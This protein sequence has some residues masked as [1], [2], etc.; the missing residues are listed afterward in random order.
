MCSRYITRVLF[1]PRACQPRA[2]GGRRGLGGGDVTKLTPGTARAAR[3]ARA[4]AAAPTVA[5]H[6]R[7]AR[8]QV[9]MAGPCHPAARPSRSRQPPPRQRGARA[10]SSAPSTAATPRPPSPAAPP[11]ATV[12]PT[13]RARATWPA[14]RSARAPRREGRQL[15]HKT[16]LARAED[17]LARVWYANQTST[18]R[19]RRAGITFVGARTHTHIR[20]TS[21]IQVMRVGSCARARVPGTSRSSQHIACSKRRAPRARPIETGAC[22][23]LRRAA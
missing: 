12:P 14:A 8:R 2:A 7:L 21:S 19:I 1:E 15:V 22:R 4:A 17:G 3:G 9:C 23:S 20:H 5:A 10:R 11:P 6:Q 16:W 13:R 18:I